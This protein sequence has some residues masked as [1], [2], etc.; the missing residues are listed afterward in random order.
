MF[1]SARKYNKRIT[2]YGQVVQSDGFGGSYGSSQT[3]VGKFW[4]KIEPLTTDRKRVDV[5]VEELLNTLVI[6][7]RKPKNIVI[8]PST[9]VIEYRGD[10]YDIQGIANEKFEDRE[11]HIVA[12]KQ[13]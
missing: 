4:A 7:I 8:D 3:L 6:K 10:K 13:K 1:G 9:H 5:G 2:I 12:I 11:L